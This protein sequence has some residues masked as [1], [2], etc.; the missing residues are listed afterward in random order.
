MLE[1]FED[2]MKIGEG[3]EIVTQEYIYRPLL[4]DLEGNSLPTKWYSVVRGDQ[5]YFCMQEI[6][7]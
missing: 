3:Y 6:M 5:Y 2:D 4:F 7:N 1:V